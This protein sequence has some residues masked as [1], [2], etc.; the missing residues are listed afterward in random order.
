M[1]GMWQH[2]N[3]KPE[4]D[5]DPGFYDRNMLQIY[6]IEQT[7]K[8]MDGWNKQYD[9]VIRSRMDM[10]VAEKLPD[11]E[12]IEENTIHTSKHG[13]THAHCCNDR[14]CVGFY[15]P[16]Y[17]YCNRYS[18]FDG[19]EYDGDFEHII[20]ET[21]LAHYLDLHRVKYKSC[22]QIDAKRWHMISGKKPL[23]RE[24]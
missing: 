22:S 12:F 20:A 8:L 17:Y 1:Q 4:K 16:M 9:V 2:E 10:F 24:V 6:Y 23:R 21:Q 13:H 7:W 18:G 19:I 11:L 5:R 14:F 15:E 3:N